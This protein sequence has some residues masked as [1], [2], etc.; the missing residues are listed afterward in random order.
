M[1]KNFSNLEKLSKT[2]HTSACN[3]CGYIESK[4]YNTF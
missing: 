1:V 3:R 4:N 2:N